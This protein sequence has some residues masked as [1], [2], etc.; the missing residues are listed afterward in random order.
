MTLFYLILQSAIQLCLG[1]IPTLII[2]SIVAFILKKFFKKFSI[3]A[4]YPVGILFLW[5]TSFSSIFLLMLGFTGNPYYNNELL[6]SILFMILSLIPYFVIK[7]NGKRANPLMMYIAWVFSLI[8]IMSAEVGS[9]L[10]TPEAK[11]IKL[12]QIVIFTVLLFLVKKK[13]KIDI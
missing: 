12:L 6:G 5:V 3:L 13:E 11:F 8:P 4:S 10:E 9:Y 2:F 1:A 7:I